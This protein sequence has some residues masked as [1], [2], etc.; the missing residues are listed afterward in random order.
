[1]RDERHAS[2]LAAAGLWAENLQP[3]KRVERA[4]AE[5]ERGAAQLWERLTADVRQ[6]RD[7]RGRWHALATAP[8]RG[9]LERVRQLLRP[10]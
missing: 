6:L 10:V 1:M 2:R 4:Q 7:D 9:C 8:R 3:R 5:R